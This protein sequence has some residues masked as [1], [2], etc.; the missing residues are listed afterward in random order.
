MDDPFAVDHQTAFILFQ[1]LLLILCWPK[2][3]QIKT[4]LMDNTEY[5]QR[6]T[7]SWNLLQLYQPER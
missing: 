3:V 4:N 6:G 5:Y 2:F 1:V 7:R